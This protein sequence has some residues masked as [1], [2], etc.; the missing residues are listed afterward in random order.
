M[1]Q[2][3]LDDLNVPIYLFHCGK[4]Y[5]AYDLLGAHWSVLDGEC[6]I[7]VFRVW[8]PNAKKIYVTGDFDGWQNGVEMQ[9]IKDSHIWQV[10]IKTKKPI[11]GCN[12]KYR[13]KTENKSFYKSDPYGFGG[14][15]FDEGNSVIY[16][17]DSYAW[18][19]NDWLDKRHLIYK[20]TESSENY[21]S[22]PINIYEVHLPSW[23]TRN[24][25]PTD[26][27]KHYLNYREIADELAE[28]VNKMGYTHVELLPI[29]EY[30]FDGSWGY[31]VTGYYTPTS[32]LGSP[33]DFKYFIDK[34]HNSGIGVILDWVPAHFPKDQHG[35]YEFD[36]QPLYE[37]TD[38][39]RME[40]EVWKTRFFDVGKN[41]VKCFLISNALFWLRKYHIDGLRVD[42]VAS[43]LYLDCDRSPGKWKPNR[44]GDNRNIDA[45]DF[46]RE[47]NTVV[48][49]EFPDVLMIAEE[50]TDWKM[51]TKAP[52]KGG[53][54]FSF[55]WNMG[56]AN[57]MFKY[58]S[59]EPK[60]RKL[61]HNLL[62]FPLMYAFNE[63]YILPV[64]HDEVVHGKKSLID[65]MM[66]NYEDKFRSMKVFMLYMMTLPGKKLSFMGCEFAQFSEWDYKKE[67]E[68]FMLKYPNHYDMQKFTANLNHFYIENSELWQIDYGWEG[69]SWIEPDQNEKS[70]ISYMRKNIN[71]E[72]LIVVLNFSDINCINYIVRVPAEGDYEI[73]FSTTDDVCDYVL[74]NNSILI[75]R[76]LANGVLS[77]DKKQT[78]IV[79][80]NLPALSGIVIKK[81]NR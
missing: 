24:S 64:S 76:S 70:T 34:M 62:T 60:K 55:K 37:Y 39:M 9:M 74:S 27:R 8:S 44:F 3:E 72:A 49:S 42:A 28:Y 59:K 11:I 2:Q 38:P 45:I 17:V 71:G 46:F 67:L 40:H 54:G 41:E 43:M 21:Y 81:C 56:W 31:Q 25:K 20:K 32:R 69:F 53:L 79:S 35:L 19:D 77:V 57:D 52:D 12:Y 16:D 78:Y 51:I 15:A 50:S 65:K 23:K 66:C 75:A 30:P 36:G 61:F 5:S 4:N 73:V 29:S 33:D 10:E 48:F 26:D 58:L 68:W 63:N 22:V 47:L 80:V 1:N 13:I 14:N 18:N 7:T 6:C